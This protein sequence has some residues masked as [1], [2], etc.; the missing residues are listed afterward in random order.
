[1]A[2]AALTFFGHGNQIWK[3]DVSDNR[4]SPED[5]VDSISYDGQSTSLVDFPKPAGS[6]KQMQHCLLLYGVPRGEPS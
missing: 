3:P 4:S 1:M 2:A 6:D 5:L